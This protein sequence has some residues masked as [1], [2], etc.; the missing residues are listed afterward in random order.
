MPIRLMLIKWLVNTRDEN[1]LWLFRQSENAP[2]PPNVI[3]A[4]P[5]GMSLYE[6]NQHNIDSVHIFHHARS[7]P[8]V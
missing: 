1:V 5:G 6:P 3:H 8:D 7:E 4:D 2:Q